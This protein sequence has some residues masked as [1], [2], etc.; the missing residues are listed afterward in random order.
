M[1]GETDDTRPFLRW[2]WGFAGALALFDA[3]LV[4]DLFLVAYGEHG[5]LARW[6]GAPWP[7]ALLPAAPLAHVWLVAGWIARARGRVRTRGASLLLVALAAGI[8][9]F[10]ALLW[11]NGA[12]VKRLL[13]L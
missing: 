3:V 11:D 13:S 5:I 6:H 12:W 1:P 9:V 10:H 7:V 2:G 4:T 8:V